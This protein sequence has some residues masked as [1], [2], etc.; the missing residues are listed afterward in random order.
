MGKLMTKQEVLKKMGAK[1]FRHVGVEQIMTFVSSIPDMDKEVAME[2]IKQFPYFKDCA[3]KITSNYNNLC[4][5]FLHDNE[6]PKLEIM[7]HQKVMDMYHERIQTTGENMSHDEYIEIM[8]LITDEAD[9]I[10]ETVHKHQDK[11]TSVLDT[12]GK[13]AAGAIMT[14]AALIGLKEVDRL[15][16]LKKN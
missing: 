9:K 6:L 8:Q 16:F 12:A 1:D 11:K 15:P 7:A 2:C 13:V 3:E 14:A 10:T 4:S 5:E